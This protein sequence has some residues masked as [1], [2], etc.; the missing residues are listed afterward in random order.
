[1][2]AYLEQTLVAAF[3]EPAG[4]RERRA[5]TPGEFT[6]P[7]RVCA[8]ADV[9]VSQCNDVGLPTGIDCGAVAVP[10]SSAVTGPT[11]GV[12]LNRSGW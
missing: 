8:S 1:M 10:H 11:P 12:P 2:G 7:G 9:T 5:Y 6:S 3:P 4:V